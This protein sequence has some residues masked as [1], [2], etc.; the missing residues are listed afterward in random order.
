MLR[1]TRADQVVPVYEQLTRLYPDALALSRAKPNRVRRIVYP[2]G[3]HWRS[4]SFQL[5]AR[6][7]IR[8]YDGRVPSTRNEMEQLPGVGPYVAGAVLSVALGKPEGIVDTNVVRVFTRYFGLLPKREA[9][10]DRRVLELAAEYAR[11]TSARTA[12]L[13]LL[14]LAALVCVPTHPDC[15]QC[16]ARI[17]CVFSRRLRAGMKNQQPETGK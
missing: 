6:E 15:G 11:G 9:R 2:L 4:D 17:R 16:P 10:R 5:V 1:R 7:L 3:L 13:G 12:N 8:R 14:D